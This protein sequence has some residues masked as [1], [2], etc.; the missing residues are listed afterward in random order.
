MI[1]FS[2]VSV[3]ETAIKH[4]P[5][6]PDLAMDPTMFHRGLLDVG[7]RELLITSEHVIAV[8]ALPP[9]HRDPFDRLLVAQAQVESLTLLTSD[10]LLVRYSGVQRV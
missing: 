2:T 1:Y 3:W 8:S 6:H 4:G 5:G 9:I 7:C 10:A